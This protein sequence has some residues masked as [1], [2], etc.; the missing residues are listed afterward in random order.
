M[1][2]K[3]QCPLSANSGNGARSPGRCQFSWRD[4][5][6]VERTTEACERENGTDEIYA[7]ERC[8]PQQP[9]IFPGLNRRVVKVRPNRIEDKV[10]WVA[11]SEDA[12]QPDDA[13]KQGK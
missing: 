4:R 1:Q 9:R 8:L 11:N 5:N 12:E 6:I 10:A 2:C 3:R 7:D 13:K